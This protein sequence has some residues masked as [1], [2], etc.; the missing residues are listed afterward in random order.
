MT[1]PDEPAGRTAETRGTDPAGTRNGHVDPGLSEELA[2]MLALLRTKGALT[3]ARLKVAAERAV[4]V[5]VVLVWAGLAFAIATVIAVVALFRGVAGAIDSVTQTSWA[6]DLA[7]G[8]LFFGG[9]AAALA[10]V[11]A[12]RRRA[13]L[14]RLQERFGP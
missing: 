11:T 3:V 10:I 1:D 6:G 7:A 9:A 12:R 8:V 14:Q 5:S 2:R 13:Q 4:W